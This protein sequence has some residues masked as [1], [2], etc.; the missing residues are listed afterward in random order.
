[1]PEEDKK[2]DNEG[3]MGKTMIDIDISRLSHRD[4]EEAAKPNAGGAV[5]SSEESVD[6]LLRKKKTLLGRLGL[7]GIFGKKDKKS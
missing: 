6:D 3:E 1:M 4:K 7:R 5:P 2:T